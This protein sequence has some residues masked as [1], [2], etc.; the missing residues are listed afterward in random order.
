MVRIILIIIMVINGKYTVK[1]PL[2]KITSPGNLPNSL[3]KICKIIP[4]IINT[5]PR[6]SKSLPIAVAPK[7]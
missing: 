3:G 7:K 5:T 6:N 1:F 4:I 2:W